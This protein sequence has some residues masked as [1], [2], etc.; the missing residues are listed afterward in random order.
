M[1]RVPTL[2]VADAQVAHNPN[3]YVYRFDWRSPGLGAAHATDVP[4]TFGTFDREGWG[5]VV[6]ADAR[7]ERLGA[8]LR[9]AWSAFARTGDPSHDGIG[10]WPAYDVDERPTMLFDA[11]CRVVRDPDAVPLAVWG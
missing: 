10:R 11:E 7:A 6:G 9:G 1:M 2:H 4:F 8:N 3:T 5:A